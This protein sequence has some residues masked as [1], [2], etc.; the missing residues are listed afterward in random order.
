MLTMILIKITQGQKVVQIAGVKDER[1]TTEE[2]KRKY[3]K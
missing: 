3:C 2:A 1:E